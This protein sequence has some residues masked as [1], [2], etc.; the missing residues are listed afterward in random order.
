MKRI[1]IVL[2]T[3]LTCIILFS[4]LWYKVAWKCY[5]EK[6]S[7]LSFTQQINNCE[8]FPENFYLTY[9][10]IHPGHRFDSFERT[11]LKK[12]FNSSGNLIPTSPSR[13]VSYTYFLAQGKLKNRLMHIYL[14]SAVESN[15]SIEKC[16]DY[17]LHNFDFLNGRKGIKSLVQEEY[18]KTVDKLSE[19]EIIE[20]T[21]LLRN[22]IL[23]NK[24][25]YPERVSRMI[26]KIGIQLE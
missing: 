7:I 4:Y 12:I 3:I 2:I 1:I 23:Y 17:Y 11:T 5:V 14:I 18:G 24:H 19:K 21:L 10:K 9:D 15:T 20:V 6:K 16:F 25:R 13:Y 8:G 22:P 26:D